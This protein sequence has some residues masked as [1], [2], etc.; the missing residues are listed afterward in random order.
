MLA[1]GVAQAK[2]TLV[3]VESAS[4]AMINRLE[5]LGLDVTYESAERTEIMLHGSEDRQILGP[6]GTAR[7]S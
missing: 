6:P 4:P 7:R 5:A 1:P 2:T 3:E